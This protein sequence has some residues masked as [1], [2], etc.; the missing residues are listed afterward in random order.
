MFFTIGEITPGALLCWILASITIHEFG[1]W[2]AALYYGKMCNFRFNG[3]DLTCGD[4]YINLFTVK[5]AL[6]ISISGVVAGLLCAIA[7]T[8]ILVILVIFYM[9]TGDFR[10]IYAMVHEK[11]KNIRTLGELNDYQIQMAEMSTIPVEQWN[12]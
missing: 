2:L 8:D 6:I 3:M 12:L 9:S 10:A 4:E 1:H 11:N 7:T 5:Q